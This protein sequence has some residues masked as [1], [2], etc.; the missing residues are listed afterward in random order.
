VKRLY[1]LPSTFGSGIG[2]E[3]FRY[4]LAWLRSGE[5]RQGRDI[6]LGVFPENPRAIKFYEKYNFKICGDYQFVVGQRSDTEY[7]MKNS[8]V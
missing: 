1:V 4:A 8:G 6:Y 5:G 7:I 2:D 3:L